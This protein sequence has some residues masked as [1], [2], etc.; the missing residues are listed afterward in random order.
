MS[1]TLY[2]IAGLFLPLFPLSMLFN[3]MFARLRHPWLRVL[4]LLAW[5]QIGVLLLSQAADPVPDWFAGWALLSAAFYAYR[6]IA[7][8]E[9]GLWIGYIATSAW[10]LLWIGVVEPGLHHLLALG[11]SLPLAFTAL[12]TGFLEQRLGAA[13]TALGGGM[14][15]AAPRFAGLFVVAV[16]AA[17][18]TPLFPNFFSLLATLLN[19]AALSPLFAL[20]LVLIWLLW[21][22]SGI[23]LLQGIV[24]GSPVRN[25]LQDLSMT[26]TWV[27]SAGFVGLLLIGINMGGVLL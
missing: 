18:A 9:V 2:L 15:I 10:A 1:L 19:P 20:G 8:R 7:L 3:Q 21:T 25:G 4:L 27:Y 16:L 13:H 17:V 26:A 24:V 5:P 6:A 11:F 12:L 22:W 23:R 14:A